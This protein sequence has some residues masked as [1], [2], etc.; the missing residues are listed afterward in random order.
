MEILESD[1]KYDELV[2]G[3]CLLMA[4]FTRAVRE[5]TRVGPAIAELSMNNWIPSIRHPYT[6]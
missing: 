2:S 3:P 6:C 4:C 5:T 1:R